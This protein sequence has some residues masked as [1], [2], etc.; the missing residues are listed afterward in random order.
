MPENAP[1][2]DADVVIAGAG[3]AGSTAALVLARAG[4]NVLL[5]DA[6]EFPRDKVCGD[7]IGTD[8]VATLARL[9]IRDVALAGAMP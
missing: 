8:A 2:V 6:R 9:G 3:P 1:R 4:R 5:L 7:L